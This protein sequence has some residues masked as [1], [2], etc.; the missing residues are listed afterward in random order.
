MELAVVTRDFLMEQQGDRLGQL[1]VPDPTP[2]METYLRE[3]ELCLS[4]SPDRRAN[5]QRYLRSNR[6]SAV[7]DYLPVRLDVENVSRCNFRC[8]MCQVSDW[9][10]SQRAAD[11]TFDDYKKLID[12]QYGL[13]EVKIQGFGEPTMGGETYFEMIK[14]A[15]AQHIW[16]RTITNGSRLHLRDTYKKL[17]DADPN[18]IQISIDGATKEVFEGIRRGSV[19]EMVVENC[20]LINRYAAEKGL[21]RT[22]MWTVVQKSNVHQLGDLVEFAREV[23]FKRMVFS[24]ELTDFGLPEW[25]VTNDMVSVCDQVD[26]DYCWELHDRAASYGIKLAFWIATERYDTTSPKKL[27]PWPFERAFVSSDMRYVPC[28]I[29]GNPDISDTGDGRKLAEEW[30][31]PAIVEFR[32]AHLEGRIPAVCKSC[33]K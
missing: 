33:Y 11:M 19:F 28:C 15:R 14:Y 5:Y 7:L 13:V 21:V 22:K 32:K 27:C 16:V 6:R 4:L 2:D 12:S 20:K 9:P 1:P 10:K 23:G 3:R 24:F 30:N 18:E 17:I 29:I 26:V 31:G 8:T 25:R